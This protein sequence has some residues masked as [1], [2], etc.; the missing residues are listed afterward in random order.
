VVLAGPALVRAFGGQLTPG[1]ALAGGSPGAALELA[2]SNL[3]R[4]VGSDGN[5]LTFEVV[6]RST[7]NAKPDGPKIEIPDP[8]DPSKIIGLADEYYVGASLAEGSA[9]AAGFWTQL[10]AGPG[11]D[12][13]PDFA[14]SSV[15]LAG[16]VRG[17]EMWRD[18]GEGW[19]ESDAI[20]GIGLDPTTLAKLPSLMRNV[21][22]PTAAGQDV[23]DGSTVAIVSGTGTIKDAPGLMA[24]DAESF[25]VLVDPIDFKIDDQGRLVQLHARMRNTNMDEFDLIVDTVITFG[26]DTTARPLPD[27]GSTAPPP[28]APLASPSSPVAS[29]SSPVASPSS[30][31][32]SPSSQG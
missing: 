8:S 27:P 5:G 22:D 14:Q 17:K 16:L 26:Y 1:V 30:P 21:T 20:P 31:V 2:A 32:A 9:S 28:P 7:L 23:V 12:A 18:D 11:K 25:T 24:I 4:A 6:A 29:P 3:E 10:R 15:T 19:Y 13:E